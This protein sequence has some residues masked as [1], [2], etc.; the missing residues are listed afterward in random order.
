[1]SVLYIL[2][3][4][5]TAAFAIS[6][7]LA[8]VRKDMDLY[9]ISVLS[10]VTAVG[11]GTIRDILVGRIPPF[12]FIDY[13]YIGISLLSALFVFFFYRKVEKGM[14]T[15]LIMDAM[16]LGVFTVIGVKVGLD[17]QIGFIGSIFMGVMTGTFGG[18]IRDILQGE[19]PLV[20]KKE[21]YASASLI[22]G[23][24]FYLL[25]NTA[26]LGFINIF[27]SISV[28]FLLRVVA[29][30]KNWNLPKPK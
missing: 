29:I 5:G 12:I 13:N 3:L 2:D 4:V 25:S 1:M 16:G 19:I 24:I 20:L 11:G 9:G 15:L 10:L 21:V 6:G 30:F 7:A 23:I 26:V 22:G 17:Y 14:K 18:M 27:L 8:G 28:V